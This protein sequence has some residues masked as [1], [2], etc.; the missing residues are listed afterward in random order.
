MVSDKTFR[1]SLM[2]FQKDDSFSAFESLPNLNFR[3]HRDRFEMFF[4]RK[5]GF[6]NLFFRKP[7]R[8]TRRV[9]KAVTGKNGIKSPERG[10]LYAGF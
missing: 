7:Q 4:C 5:Q 3:E 10:R 8:L 9:P 6:L 2:S 1:G